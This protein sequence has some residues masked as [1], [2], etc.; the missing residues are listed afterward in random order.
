MSSATDRSARRAPA[1]AR[2]DRAPSRASSTIEWNQRSAT[3]PTR[4]SLAGGASSTSTASSPTL[5]AACSRGPPSCR[6]TKLSR[7]SDPARSRIVR[8]SVSSS[9]RPGPKHVSAPV[10][11]AGPARVAEHRARCRRRSRRRARRTSSVLPDV[12]PFSHSSPRERLQNVARPLERASA[13]APR[14]SPTPPSAPRRSSRPG[15]RM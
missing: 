4:S 3:S 11:Q 15:R 14:G 9:A 12:A 8:A 10:W 13:R 2:A 6:A 5:R 1:A 7:G